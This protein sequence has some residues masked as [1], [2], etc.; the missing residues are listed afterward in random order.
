M[1]SLLLPILSGLG[2]LLAG[3][4]GA[5]VALRTLKP[6]VMVLKSQE[7]K[8]LGDAAESAA[9]ALVDLIKAFSDERKQFDTRIDELEA[10]LKA[11]R[12]ETQK[13]IEET[14]VHRAET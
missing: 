1:E 2:G 7:Q 4:V 8:N 14:A 13:R 10:E 9:G 12:E 5:Y 6:N 11:Q 3:V